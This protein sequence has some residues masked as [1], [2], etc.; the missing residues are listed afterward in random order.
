[1]STFI[2]VIL[3]IVIL[4]TIIGFVFFTSKLGN[5]FVPIKF[6][7]WLLSIYI[8]LLVLSTA[9]LPFISDDRMEK[10]VRRQEDMDKVM[11]GLFSK[12]RQ[13]KIDQIPYQ[14][15]L[16]TNRFDDYPNQTLT[17]ALN[18]DH[19]AEILVERK[20][21]NDDSIESFT[22]ANGLIID[23][24]DFSNN[25]IPYSIE[26]VDNKLT[27]HPIVQDIRISI[28]S[29]SFPVRQFTG[30]SILDHS[31]SSRHQIIYLKIPSDLK[32]NVDESVNLVYV[33]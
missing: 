19:G 22:Y 9:I 14:Y 6:T 26:L 20:T 30:D 10:E 24:I 23:G 4:I 7:H 13:G 28:T 3:P 8:F 18:S 5:C 27:I 12:L 33:K 15:V 21:N 1:M 25:L 29:S 32:I 31:F 2:M 16:Q 11:D 17:I